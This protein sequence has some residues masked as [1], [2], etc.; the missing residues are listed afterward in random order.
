MGSALWKGNQ[1]LLYTVGPS[2]GLVCGPMTLEPAPLA[3]PHA[4][5]QS[6]RALPVLDRRRPRSYDPPGI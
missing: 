5:A 2:R 6:R 1:G 4:L 3:Y